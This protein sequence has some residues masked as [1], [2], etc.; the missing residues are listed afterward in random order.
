VLTGDDK[1][2]VLGE[3]GDL[4]VVEATPS[5]YRE[6]SRKK[7]LGDRCWVQPALANGVIYCRNNAG[8]LVALAAGGK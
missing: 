1:L 7:V 2:I 3:T 8:E 6:L 5:G 4:I